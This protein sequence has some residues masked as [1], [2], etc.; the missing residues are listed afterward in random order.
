MKRSEF[1]IFLLLAKFFFFSIQAAEKKDIIFPKVSEKDLQ[2]ILTYFDSIPRKVKY[3]EDHEYI[4]TNP[5]SIKKH[6]ILR[7]Y[8]MKENDN[9][10]HQKYLA[11]AAH[12]GAPSHGGIKI[13]SD[14][15]PFERDQ[16]KKY[17]FYQKSDSE[18]IFI[19]RKIA[20]DVFAG[21]LSVKNSIPLSI[22]MYPVFRFPGLDYYYKKTRFSMERRHLLESF[23][24]LHG[25]FFYVP[26]WKYRVR[27]RVKRYQYEW[28]DMSWPY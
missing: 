25:A 13:Y 20:K 17:N 27:Y 16:H 8:V 15:Y 9:I 2:K 5:I 3:M 1:F 24:E 14:R 28:Q 12:S 21:V 4:A 10:L 18:I 19:P 7:Y 11:G 23:L 22:K 26:F 6:F